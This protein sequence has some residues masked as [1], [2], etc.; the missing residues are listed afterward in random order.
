M[1]GIVRFMLPKSIN[2]KGENAYVHTPKLNFCIEMYD[3]SLGP[4]LYTPTL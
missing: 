1:G 2:K 4:P 3:G